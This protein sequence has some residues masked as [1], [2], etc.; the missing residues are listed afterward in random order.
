MIWF[1]LLQVIFSQTSELLEHQSSMA[2]SME[3]MSNMEASGNESHVE[4]TTGTDGQF[5]V[6]KDFDFLD[7]EESEVRH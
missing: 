2:S 6:F 5:T 4:D 7:N 1:L 3:E